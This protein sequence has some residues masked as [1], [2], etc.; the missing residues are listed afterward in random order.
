MLDLNKAKFF[1]REY[2]KYHRLTNEEIKFIPD[3]V[4]SEYI[5]AFYYN[6]YLLEHDPKRGKIRRL[7]LYSKSAKWHHQNKD[8]IIKVLTF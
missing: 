5:D 7:S 8:K 2:R 4:A 3:L 1:L 6:Y